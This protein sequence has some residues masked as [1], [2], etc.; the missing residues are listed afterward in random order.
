MLFTF[1]AKD[2]SFNTVSPGTKAHNIFGSFGA[3]VSDML[4][5]TL[6]MSSYFFAFALLV[7]GYRILARRPVGPLGAWSSLRTCADSF[8]CIGLFGRAK[9]STF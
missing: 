9:C 1:D 3:Y 5:Q 8:L 6:G 7:W 4:L 2:P